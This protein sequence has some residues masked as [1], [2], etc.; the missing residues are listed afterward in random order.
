MRN[1]NSRE[2]IQALIVT[3]FKLRS[4]NSNNIIATVM[5]IEHPQRI[6]DYFEAVL[7]AFEKDVFPSKFGPT[8]TQGDVLIR[9]HTSPIANALFNI[10]TNRLAVICDGTYVKHEK[11]TNS[12]YQRKSFSGQKKY[13]LCKPFTICATDGFIIDDAGPYEGTKNDAQIM[14]DVLQNPNGIKRSLRKGDIFIVDR[15]FRDVVSYLEEQGFK[16]LM[17][18]VKGKRAKLTAEESN[19][20]RFVT[21]VRWVVESDHG[22]IGRRWKL[23]HNQLDNKLLPKVKVSFYQ[24]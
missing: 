8:A 20:S 12:L 10:G 18:A 3:L 5:D 16:V 23:L 22:I 21:K 9:E 4:G 19:N 17:P 14:K 7:N 24:R 2:V 1:S 13:N 6:S 15:G 11:S